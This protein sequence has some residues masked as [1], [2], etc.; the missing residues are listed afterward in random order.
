MANQL[1]I[2]FQEVLQLPA[3]GINPQ[4]IGFATLTMESYKYICVREQ[5]EKSSVVIIDLANPQNITRR[6]ITADSAIMNPTQNILALKAGNQLQIFNIEKKERIKACQMNDVV[7]FWK[8]ISD[9]SIGIVTG[10]NVY[11][12]NT[13]DATSEPVK[14]FE[15]HTSLND[16]QIINYRT[17]RSG[18][19]LCVVGIAQ[20]EGRIVGAMQLYS[21]DKKVSQAIEGHAA[22]FSEFTPEGASGPSVLFSFANRNL[23]TPNSWQRFKQCR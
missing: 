14:V 17:D 6:P 16:C 20:R 21:V 1:P 7:L 23:S 8:W 10:T 13:E 3:L 9:N 2:R 22:A 11:H 15:R 19:W 12:W 18:K 5:S 4:A